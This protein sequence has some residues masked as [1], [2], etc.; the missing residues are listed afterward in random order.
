[1]AMLS[2]HPKAWRE[3]YGEEVADLVASRPARLR[4]VLDLV[5]GAADAWLHHRRIP[6]A[7]TLTVPLAAT[8]VCSG[9]AL[10]LLWNLGLRDPAG[11]RGAWADAAGAGSIAGQL[12]DL[13]GSST[14]WRAPRRCS[15]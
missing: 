1:M 2:L 15:R 4:T 5:S 13:A 10:L 3:R 6:R 14:P 7:G 8:L 12:H 9:A 11:L